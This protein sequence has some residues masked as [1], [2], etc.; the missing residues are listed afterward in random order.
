MNPKVFLVSPPH[1]LISIPFKRR[2]HF[3]LLINPFASKHQRCKTISKAKS[4]PAGALLE[5]SLAS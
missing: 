4:S 3:K 5:F 1:S 2:L